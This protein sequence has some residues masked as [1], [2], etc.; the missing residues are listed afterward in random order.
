MQSRLL[1][2]SEWNGK[3]RRPVKK[4]KGLCQ[5]RSGSTNFDSSACLRA[6]H[7]PADVYLPMCANVVCQ[8]KKME[9]SHQE[10][11]E[12]EVERILGYLKSYYQDDRMFQICHLQGQIQ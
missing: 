6:L 12:K 3:E 7:T 5:L 9:D 4:S 10:A 11:T 1:Q 2:S 8:L